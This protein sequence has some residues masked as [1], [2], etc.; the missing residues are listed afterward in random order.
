MNAI[1]IN[2]IKVPHDITNAFLELYLFQTNQ[3]RLLKV[4][5]HL[6]LRIHIVLKEC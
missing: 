1:K 4:K 3:I 6:L 5:V 2:V